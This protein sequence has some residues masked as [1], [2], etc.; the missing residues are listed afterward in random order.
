MDGCSIISKPSLLPLNLIFIKTKQK[1]ILH[2]QQQQLSVIFE[3]YF[4]HWTDV[5]GMLFFLHINFSSSGTPVE[6]ATNEFRF[7]MFFFLHCQ[8]RW[9][10]ENTSIHTTNPLLS[11]PKNLSR[12]IELCVDLLINIEVFRGF[13]FFAS[14][15]HLLYARVLF[16][17]L[18][19]SICTID[20]CPLFPLLSFGLIKYVLKLKSRLRMRLSLAKNDELAP[21]TMQS[22]SVCFFRVLFCFALLCFIFAIKWDFTSKFM[23]YCRCIFVVYRPWSNDKNTKSLFRCSCY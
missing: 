1:K 7:K 20:V 6:C 12:H 2:Q 4:L 21:R 18:L 5:A 8:R 9:Y 22:S 17:F 11:S 16:E 3:S 19:Q 14:H 23:A 13:A 15:F 10:D